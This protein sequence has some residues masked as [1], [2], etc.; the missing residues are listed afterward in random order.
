[1]TSKMLEQ[2]FRVKKARHMGKISV[3]IDEKKNINIFHYATNICVINNE[4][5]TFGL[6]DGFY[7]TASTH[8]HIN[9]LYRLLTRKHY[10]LSYVQI[11]GVNFCKQ[12]FH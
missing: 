12:H 6:S 4:D 1:M 3:S 8:K 9:D 7:N 10:K 5:K 11:C 2:V